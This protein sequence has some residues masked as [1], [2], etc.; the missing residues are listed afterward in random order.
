MR[1]PEVPDLTVPRAS[2]TTVRGLLSVSLGA[3]LSV[4]KSLGNHGEMGAVFRSAVRPRLM[5]APG[6]FASSMLEPSRL[7]LARLLGFAVDAPIATRR[8]W[9]EAL[10]ASLALDVAAAEGTSVT[11][12]STSRHTLI[13]ERRGVAFDVP[14]GT[15][16]LSAHGVSVSGTPVPER[17][18]SAPLADAARLVLVDTNPLSDVEAH[19]DKLGNALDLGGRSV[20]A[21]QQ[22]LTSS[23]A[24]IERHLPGLYAEMRLLLRHVVPVGYDE[25]KHLSASYLEAIGVVYLTLHPQQMT[26]VEALIHEFQHNKLNLLLGLDPVLDNGE[27]PLF[28]SP[29]RP[30]PRPLRGVLLA[31]HAF[32]PIAL[33]YEK[34]LAEPDVNR[35]ELER[36]LGQIAKTCREGCDVLLP[37]A[38]PTRVGQPLFDEIAAL[39]RRLEVYLS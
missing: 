15:M 6:L 25:H 4:A 19:P 8:G 39:D 32:Q 12:T 17:R 31:V 23:L 36:R 37:N 11:M 5:M 7:T 2:S 10:M 38:R 27:E 14:Q 16:T 20:D 1:L 18:A 34:L 29:V 30:D 3:A 21:W 22:S 33:L 26:M 28:S 24:L 35:A 9:E 13:D